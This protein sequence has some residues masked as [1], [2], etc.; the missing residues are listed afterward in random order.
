MSIVD[1][2][3]CLHPYDSFESFDV[4]DLHI[5]YNHFDVD[6]PGHND[7]KLL[8]SEYIHYPKKL[9]HISQKKNLKIMTF[10]ALTV[11]VHEQNT[12]PLLSRLLKLIIVIPSTTATCERNFQD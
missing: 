8:L 6:F 10:V 4:K 2:S 9:N 1:A 11:W 3:E 5:L 12:S 7:E